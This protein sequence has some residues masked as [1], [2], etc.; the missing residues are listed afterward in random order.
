MVCCCEQGNELLC[1]IKGRNSWPTEERLLSRRP[2]AVG[3]CPPLV[4]LGMPAQLSPSACLQGKRPSLALHEWGL[5]TAWS[6][7]TRE[8]NSCTAWHRNTVFYGTRKFLYR[9]V[10]EVLTVMLMKVH[11]A[12]CWWRCILQGVD[13]GASCRGLMKVHLAGSLWRVILQVLMKEHL[14]GCWWRCIL[15]GG[16]DEVAYCSVLMKFHFAGCS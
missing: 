2:C 1:S 8:A 3:I 6:R 10:F 14:A 9:S 15:Q 13:E 7:H 5:L 16:V 11:I 12:G 4:L